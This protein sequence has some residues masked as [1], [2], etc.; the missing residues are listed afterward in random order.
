MKNACDKCWGT[1]KPLNHFGMGQKMLAHR[2][3]R[4]I[5]QQAAAARLDISPSHL[6]LLEAGKRVWGRDLYA[7]ALNL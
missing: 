1:G 2:L 5:S 4:G 3:R 6:S 7:R